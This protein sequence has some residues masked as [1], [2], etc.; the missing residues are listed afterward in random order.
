[1]YA[2]PQDPILLD[3]WWELPE[4]SVAFFARGC[5][6]VGDNIGGLR[7]INVMPSFKEG[8][9][10]PCLQLDVAAPVQQPGS[11]SYLSHTVYDAATNRAV[12]TWPLK[13]ESDSTTLGTQ[14]AYQ[15]VCQTMSYTHIHRNSFE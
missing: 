15:Q 7:S 2:S 4:C 3:A 9:N 10:L 1:M 13:E 14:I 6:L 8:D 11:Y 12:A 5:Q